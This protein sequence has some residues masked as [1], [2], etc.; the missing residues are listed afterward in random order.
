MK[1]VVI[2]CAAAAIGI[3]AAGCTSQSPQQS[4]APPSAALKN[5]TDFP[6]A[7]QSK[8]LDVQPFTQTVTVAQG[9]ESTLTS[10]GAGTYAG[11][12]LI[13]ATAESP[14]ALRA[15]LAHLGEHPP[16]GYAYVTGS[17]TVS[18][19]MA[20]EL[21]LYGVSYAVFRADSAA[22]NRRIVIVAMDPKLVKAKLG[23]ALDLVDRYRS[24][25]QALRDPIDQQFKAKTGFTITQATDP[26]SPLG[27]TLGALHQLNDNDQ[28]AVVMIDGSKK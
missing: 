14:N 16:T 18:S 2:L 6:L 20:Q 7:P 13:A 8:I 21:D 17:S 9:N 26:S 10:Q 22:A 1:G 3:G 27:M 4:S 28:R 5:P 25:P 12:E 19:R 11:T 23:L 24:L 15:W